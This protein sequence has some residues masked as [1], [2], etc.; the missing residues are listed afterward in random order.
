MSLF[1]KIVKTPNY[2]C[3]SSIS[4]NKKQ[5]T[6]YKNNKNKVKNIFNSNSTPKINNNKFISYINY[7]ILN[8]LKLK[9]IE[10]PRSR[11][12]LK[13]KTNIFN[14][15]NNLRLLK[16]TI[17]INYYT[18]DMEQNKPN[19]SLKLRNQKK[20]KDIFNTIRKGNLTSAVMDKKLNFVNDDFIVNKQ[21]NDKFYFKDDYS[22]ITSS[23]NIRNKFETR[24]KT[25]IK[26]K[27][28]FGFNDSYSL[29]D[30]QSNITKKEKNNLI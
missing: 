30:K 3:F 22:K 17:S 8:H 20:K 26:K 1:D 18:K 10:T 14:A 4:R 21:N 6:L 23:Q 15:N 11:L 25:F 28:K 19:I 2:L 13:N 27:I 29:K 24:H 7:N 5:G 9:S 16:R 12:K